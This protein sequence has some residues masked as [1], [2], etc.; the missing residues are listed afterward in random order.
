MLRGFRSRR[1]EG[2]GQVDH[3]RRVPA[4]PRR[5]LPAD[6][7]RQVRNRHVRPSRRPP[8]AG[9]AD[10]RHPSRDGCSAERPRRRY[11][12]RGRRPSLRPLRRHLP[13]RTSALV[14]V[15]LSPRVTRSADLPWLLAR[16][17]A[18]Q[19]LDEL[20]RRWGERIRHMT[21]IWNDR[22]NLQQLGG[23]E[24]ARRVHQVVTS[25]TPTLVW[26]SVRERHSTAHAIAR[27]STIEKRSSN[28][29]RASSA[30]WSRWRDHAIA[31][32]K[33]P[34]RMA[35]ANVSPKSLPHGSR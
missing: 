20:G 30:R 3:G 11:G 12:P 25:G 23:R 26:A 28:P 27:R 34:I 1:S 21:K 4:P 15:N 2:C 7:F 16:A 29:G 18:E 32:A 14:L 22:I 19:R 35:S 5:N 10:G 24:A 31:W 33:A 9:D 6:R 13:E 17:E 8:Y